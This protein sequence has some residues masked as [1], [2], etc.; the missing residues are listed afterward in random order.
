[1]KTGPCIR[2]IATST[3]RQMIDSINQLLKA[4]KMENPKETAN[5]KN[6]ESAKE[7]NMRTL[8]PKFCSHCRVILIQAVCMDVLCLNRIAAADC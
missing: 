7:T 6:L 1:L 8:G 4:R 3:Y 5:S 2:K